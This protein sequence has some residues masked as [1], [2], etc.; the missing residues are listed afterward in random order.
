MYPD[1]PML[2]LHDALPVVRN[3][4][5]PLGRRD[6]KRVHGVIARI[7]GAFRRCGR[8]RRLLILSLRWN[9]GAEGGNAAEPDRFPHPLYSRYR[10]LHWPLFLKMLP[11]YFPI[12]HLPQK[13]R[14]V[15]L[16]GHM[17]ARTPRRKI[18]SEEHTSEI[19]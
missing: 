8:E 1:C 18:R 17:A 12:K 19:Q 10:R 7:V 16:K 3:R 6:D 9:Y 2:S 5:R 11:S 15:R 13:W 4:V 14:A